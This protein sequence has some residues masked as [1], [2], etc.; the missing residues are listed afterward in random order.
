VFITPQ[1]RFDSASLSPPGFEAILPALAWPVVLGMFHVKHRRAFA[2]VSVVGVTYATIWLAIQQAPLGIVLAGVS[3][4]RSPCLWLFLSLTALCSLIRIPYAAPAYTFYY[5][6]LAVLAVL[7][8]PG[9]RPFVLPLAAFLTAFAVLFVN[10]GHFT[11]EGDPIPDHGLTHL[12]IPRAGT[13]L[14]PT[15]E[16]ALYE[17]LV[18]TVNA[19]IPPNAD[20]YAAPD[21]PQVEY[22]THRPNPTPTF[23]DFLDAPSTHDAVALRAINSPH[24]AGAVIYHRP[25]ASSPIDPTISAALRTQF[26]DSASIGTTFTVRWRPNTPQET[27]PPPAPRPSDPTAPTAQTA[28]DTHAPPSPD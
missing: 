3:S 21:C 10:P 6:P 14:V 25:H 8:L 23:L 20:L 26:P 22:L 15:H 1:R 11:A 16:A 17:A 18:D 28:R 12:T 27:A 13:L 7:A 24:T 4:R 2:T 5:A 19:H 9:P